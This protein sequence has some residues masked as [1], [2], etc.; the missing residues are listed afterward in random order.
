[1]TSESTDQLNQLA[2][3]LENQYSGEIK[4][5]FYYVEFQQQNP[6]VALSSH[7]GVVRSRDEP[8]CVFV[9]IAKGKVKDIKDQYIKDGYADVIVTF[10]QFNTL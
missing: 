5:Y 6:I 4:T 10:K 2:K 8:H 7:S 9:Q 3:Q 1:M